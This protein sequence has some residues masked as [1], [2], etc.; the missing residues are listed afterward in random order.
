MTTMEHAR[1][2]P[3][4]PSCDTKNVGPPPLR[5]ALFARYG[6]LADLRHDY[7]LVLVDRIL[8]DAARQEDILLRPLTRVIDDALGAAAPKG[9]E[10]EAMRQQVLR[11]EGAIRR[12]VADGAEQWLSDIWRD[13]AAAMI[14][15]SGESAFGPLDTRLETVRK[16]LSVDG[17]VIDCDAR[18]PDRVLTHVWLAKHDAKAR[19][20]RKKVEGLI[21]RL[22]DILKSDHMKS[23]EAH[24]P[25]SLA[26]AM[27]TTSEGAIDFSALSQVLTRARPEDRLPEDRVRRIERV[28]EVL[29]CQP[30]F[31]PGRASETCPNREA[32]YSYV[33]DSCSAALDAHRARLQDVLEFTKALTVAELE[34]VH[35]YEPELHDP[36]FD[37][38]DE[39]DLTAEQMEL[40]PSALIRLRDG[41]TESAEVARAY[42]ALA[43]GLPMTVV[44][45]VD[46]LLGPTAPEPPLNS[47]GSGTARLAAMAMGLNNAFVLQSSA[48]HL[49]RMQ[50][51]LVRGIHHEGP[52]LFSVYSGAT[53]TAPGL[54]AYILSAA[55]TEARA[56]PGFTYDPSAGSDWAGRFDLS[57]N[58]QVERDWPVH[59]FDFVDSAGQR[60]TET[61][62]FTF[63][64][65]AIADTRYAR[66]C[67]A[68]EREDEFGRLDPIAEWLKLGEQANGD[69][70]PFVFGID[71]D[72]AL[73]REVVDEKIS[74]AA[75]RCN[76]AWRR[77]QELA[78][79]NNSHARRLLDQERRRREEL[80]APVEPAASPAPV[81]EAAV[82]DVA[83]EVA[84]ETQPDGMPWIETPRCTTCNECTQISSTLFAYNDDMQAFVA[85]PDGG[86]Y[87]QLVEA[88]E[89][90]QVSIIHP[91]LPRDPE[92]P[93]LEA[94][95]ERAR[96]FN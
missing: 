90:C 60:K 5:P 42:E 22:T 75:R 12:K 73:R 59:E 93:D 1:I 31:G 18:T 9:P 39:S 21:L 37:R 16:R 96:P 89:S 14:Q 81:A 51:G 26:S 44:I 2:S 30:F 62:E 92:E 41:V 91:G 64:D 11:L 35:C 8:D 33:F 66:F 29:R 61:V 3:D 76:D 88:A 65:F 87:R 46:D 95:I 55:A 71:A 17:A 28:L 7:P 79:I 48:A 69:S 74:Q 70:A 24:G 10:G 72:N 78:G 63:A 4:T 56:F 50:E 85:D 38:F 54:P 6:S 82:P 58:P 53:P 49:Y 45:Q 86:T 36:V 84:A 20:F 15:Q 27:G 43:C 32:P 77:L 57:C 25:A 47:F 94:L 40:L 19:R 23:D 52:A 68:L 67:H 34:V 13:C 83:P 80:A